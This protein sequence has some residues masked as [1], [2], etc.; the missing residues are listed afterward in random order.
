MNLTE[1]KSRMVSGSF[2]AIAGEL[3]A[4]GARALSYVVYAKLLSPT[5]FGLIGFAL[6][7]VNLFPMVLD[8]SLGL[9]L[10][11]SAEQ[12]DRVQSTTFYLNVALA[13]VGIALLCLVSPWA[14]QFLH[15]S[16]IA[17]VLPV[18]SIQLLLNSLCSVHMASARRKFEYRRL[19]PVRL[20]ASLCS[21][22][23]GLPLAF[24]GAGFWALVAASIGGPL[25]Q[26]IAAHVLLRWWPKSRF[27][28]QI[29][30]AISSFASWVAI[31]MGVTWMVMSGGGFFLAFYLGT[32]DL[33]MF[34][35]SDQID[36]YCLGTVFT[37]LIPVLY[38]S[39]CEVSAQPGASWRIFERSTAVLTPISLA[40]AGIVII[41]SSPVE[42]MIGVRWHGVSGVIMLNA[43]ADG[44]S[45]GTLAVPSLLRAHGLAKVVALLRVGTV[46]GQ[47]AVYMAVAPRGLTA[48][49]YGKLALEIAIYIVSFLILRKTFARPVLG[50]MRRQFWQ[51][52]LVAL[53]SAAGVVVARHTAAFGA[54]AALAA[55]V[56]AFCVPVGAFLFATQRHAVASAVHRWVTAR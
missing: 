43:V 5:D 47:V 45:Y 23:L 13:L 6:L 14:G 48:F 39:F 50:I 52:A 12:D 36:T 22:A 40:V 55:G 29:A 27:D 4:G 30:K 1:L 26:M 21:L 19:A 42:A 37:P 41:A 9:A 35:L 44:I 46:I 8:N 11:R 24:M 51:A 38:G 15:D 18:L 32:H 54:A 16:R 34:R 33:G 31:D 10:M 49:L 28:W 7:I 17:V 25:G 56:L 2:W 20:I 53:C 3:A